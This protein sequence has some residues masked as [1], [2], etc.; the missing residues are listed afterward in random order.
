[1]ASRVV[2]LESPEIRRLYEDLLAE[3][4]SRLSDPATDRN[5]LCRDLLMQIHFGQGA[6][7][8]TMLHDARLPL[9][10]RS[11]VASMDPRNVTLEPE[12]YGEMDVER[13]YRAKPLLWLWQMFDHSTLGQNLDLGSRVRYTLARHL[14]QRIGDNVRFFRGVEFS[15]GYNMSVGSNVTFHRYVLIDDRGPIT[16]GDNVSL[17]DWANVYT[18]TH[19]V[20]EIQDVSILPTTLGDGVR[21]TYHSTV[22]AGVRMGKEAMLGSLGVATKDIPPYHV[23]VGIPAKTVKIKGKARL[24]PNYSG[25]YDV[26]R[27][28]RKE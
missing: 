17:S 3:L 25:P 18:H 4:Q 10:T 23:A 1:M 22:L 11:L 21:V 2:A 16:I 28:A 12:Y 14:F 27:S 26:E 19:S 7:Y 20:E 5:L 9:A 8:Q 24:D 6:D 15:F 13:Y